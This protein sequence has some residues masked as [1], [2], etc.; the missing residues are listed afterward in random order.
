M[1]QRLCV[2]VLRVYGPAFA[3][4]PQ[5]H[6]EPH[7]PHLFAIKPGFYDV[8]TGNYALSTLPLAEVTQLLMRIWFSLKRPTGYAV[9]RDH[10]SHPAISSPSISTPNSSQNAN[11]TQL[12]MHRDGYWVYPREKL[13][14]LF[15]ATGFDYH[16][17]DLW[18][19][20][21]RQHRLSPCSHCASTQTTDRL[22]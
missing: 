22:R 14:S 15:D 6:F 20:Q 4:S 9:L 21:K 2:E 18:P 17:V 19:P 3:P 10:L 1:C 16:I 12:I 8:I 13:E 7:A 11:E 5:F